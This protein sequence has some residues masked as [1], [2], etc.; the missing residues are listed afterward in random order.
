MEGPVQAP[1]SSNNMAPVSVSDSSTTSTSTQSTTSTSDGD[2][3]SSTLSSKCE[4]RVLPSPKAI[5]DF[6][7]PVIPAAAPADP[8][9]EQVEHAPLAPNSNAP[10]ATAGPK[11]TVEASRNQLESEESEEEE[12]GCFESFF[13]CSLAR[14]VGPQKKQLYDLIAFSWTHFPK[15]WSDVRLYRSSILDLDWL[16]I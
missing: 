8:V 2:G 10:A 16:N 3:S 1:A 12:E 11:E 4:P 15:F 13:F 5:E 14:I 7:I 6:K 9:P